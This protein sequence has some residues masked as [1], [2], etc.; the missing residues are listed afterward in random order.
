MSSLDKLDKRYFLDMNNIS[1]IPLTHD[2]RAMT[3]SHI[4][5]LVYT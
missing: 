2:D 3:Y 4:W 1:H 5:L